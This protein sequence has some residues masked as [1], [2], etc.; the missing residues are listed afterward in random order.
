MKHHIQLHLAVLSLLLVLSACTPSGST[1]PPPPPEVSV[2]TPLI[3]EVTD[4]DEF[5]GRLAAVEQV[6]VRARVSGYLQAVKFKEGGYVQA[7]DSLFVIDPRPAQALL[8]EATAQLSQAKARLELASNDQQRAERLFKSKSISAEVLDARTQEKVEAAAAVEAAQAKVESVRLELEFT[9]VKAPISGRIGRALVTEGNLISGGNENATL[10]TTIVSLDPIHAYFTGNE[11][12]YLRY[13]RLDK[14]GG[15]SSSHYAPNPA[16][17]RLADEQDYVHQGHVDFLDNHLDEATGTVQARAIFANP[18][19]LLVPGMFADI[20][21]MGEGPYSALLIPDAAIGADQS[22][23]FVYVLDE[24]NKTHRRLVEPGR[25]EQGLRII[26]QG[27]Q[28]ED[29]VV[30][31]G[32]QRVRDGVVVTPLEVSLDNAPTASVAEPAP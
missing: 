1:E 12:A 23:Q 30:V 22:Q 16:R 17:L 32:L 26:R 5:T 2:A 10:L 11:R 13:L 31:S 18:D 14:A 27:L 29:R 20:Q 4:W 15:R 28:P 3:R 6:Q 21:L 24:D 19:G 9:D 7:G 8:N 25:M